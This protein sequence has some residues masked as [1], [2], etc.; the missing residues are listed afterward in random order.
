MNPF[1]NL[2][3]HERLFFL[4]RRGLVETGF[5]EDV[6]WIVHPVPPNSW[7]NLWVAGIVLNT[8]QVTQFRF[9]ERILPRCLPI[10]MRL[11]SF[12]GDRVLQVERTQ[13]VRQPRFVVAAWCCRRH[14]L[15]HVPR[16]SSGHLLSVEDGDDKSGVLLGDVFPTLYK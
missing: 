14:L 2:K 5:P 8:L 15:N 16:L 7:R 4:I 10:E 13:Q 12:P 6:F 3:G 9:I 1:T 11:R